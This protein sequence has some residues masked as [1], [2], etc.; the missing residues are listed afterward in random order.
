MLIIPQNANMNTRI[1]K[2]NQTW[3]QLLDS[4]DLSETASVLSSLQVLSVSSA[5][6]RRHKLTCDVHQ[7]TAHARLPSSAAGPSLSPT[8]LPVKSMHT[9]NKAHM[10]T[11]YFVLYK[12]T[13]Y[14]YY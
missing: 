2:P 3:F 5:S 4:A 9:H 11:I 8:H 7:L 6:S 14:Y 10:R 12:C 13:H 1:H